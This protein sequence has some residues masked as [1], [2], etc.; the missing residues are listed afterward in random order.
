MEGTLR[1]NLP[2]GFVQLTSGLGP[3][4]QMTGIQAVSTTPIPPGVTDINF[5]YFIP[6]QG[7]E[8]NINRKTDY[9]TDKFSLL[10]Q[11]AGVKVSSTAL[12][13]GNS[14]MMNGMNFL[15]FTASN[16]SGGVNLDASL[17]GVVKPTAASSTSFVLW[18][19]LIGGAGVLGIIG[20]FAYSRLKTRNVA[21]E[22]ENPIELSGLL[23]ELARLD[24]AHE[25]GDIEEKEYRLKRGMI[26]A[27]LV[28]A[29][30]RSPKA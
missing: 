23:E 2:E 17:S 4:V 29:Y 25:A 9:P 5:S 24:D 20:A 14:Q 13:E 1:F 3:S 11:D 12:S 22:H 18:P 6:Y 26:K 7:S 21:P 28:E 8:M 16:I 27:S 10:L 15:Y 30:S 19:W